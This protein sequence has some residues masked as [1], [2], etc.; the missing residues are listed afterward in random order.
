MTDGERVDALLEER[1]DLEPALETTLAVDDAQDT[2]TF[3]DLPIESGSFGELVSRG[4]VESAGD[5]YRLADPVAVRTALEDGSPAARDASASDTSRNGLPAF[6]LP[7]VDRTTAALVGVALAVVALVRVYS[8]GAVYRGSDVVL[9]GN[10]PYYYRYWVEQVATQ[11]GSP[12]DLGALEALPQ[13]VRA[14]EPLTVAALWWVSE[15]LGGGAA[16]VGHVL[17]WYPVASAVATAGLVYLLAVRV[18]GDRRVGLASILVLAILP[19]HALRTS[20]GFA[21]HHAFDYPW[22]AAT[23]LCLVVLATMDRERLRGPTGVL[24]TLGFGVA[25]AAQVLAW[26]AGPLLIAPIGLVVVGRALA[27][28]HAAR[29]PVPAGVPVLAG[30]AVAAGLTWLAHATFGW[31]TTVVASAPTLLLA[32][33]AGA[34]AVAVAVHR[35][36]GDV[37]HLAVADGLAVVLAVGVVVLALPDAWATLTN[38]LDFLFSSHAAVETNSLFDPASFDFLLLFGFGLVLALPVMVLAVRAAVDDARWLI[39]TVYAWYFFALA[40]IQVRFVGELG[41]FAAL[42]AGI[43]FVKLAAWVD[44]LDEG[45]PVVAGGVASGAA[46]LRRLAVP[47]RRTVGALLALFVLV[48]AFGAVQTGIKIDQISTEEAT[49]DAAAELRAFDADLDRTYP[50]NYVLSRW[51]YNRIYNYF[52]NGEAASYGFAQ[53]THAEFITAESPGDWYD[54]LADRVGYLVLEDHDSPPESMHARLFDAYGSRQGEVAGLGHYRATYVHEGGDRAAFALVPGA[55]VTGTAAPNATVSVTTNVSVP[56]ASFAYERE[57]TANRSGAYALRVAYPGDYR[58]GD[59][60]S[61]R[62][63]SVPERAV[64][65]GTDVAG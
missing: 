33:A 31:H 56:G 20:L 62:T 46:S 38:R 59:G 32:G 61:V 7:D 21:D 25:V 48:G 34:L 3:D 16:T 4:V 14:G 51:G 63:V 39:A 29:S 11:S 53:R 35:T 42:F 18:T 58:L 13:A 27:D 28:V 57:T 47:D 45:V 49:Y 60:E 36:T 2:W 1:P 24:V 5:E 43:G 52:V 26:E 19:G 44:I 37:R 40:T 8:I 64:W 22:L 30:L 23:A 55:T 10:D 65:N 17:A 12:F 6:S 15:L 9:S 50:E 41:A 54:R